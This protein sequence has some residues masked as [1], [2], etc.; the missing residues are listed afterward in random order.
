MR[1]T[2]S[3]QVSLTARSLRPVVKIVVVAE[4][5]VSALLLTTVQWPAPQPA[6]AQI[7]VLH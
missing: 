7:A 3:D 2:H 1:D 6:P 5:A 4:L